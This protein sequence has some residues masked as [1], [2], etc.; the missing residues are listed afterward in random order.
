MAF[1]V[2]P[3]SFFHAQNQLKLFA[4]GTPL[5]YSWRA[6]RSPSR[7]G[8][9]KPRP[10][11]HPLRG[12]WR[13]DSGAFGARRRWTP[14][15]LISQINLWLL[16]CDRPCLSQDTRVGWRWSV[17]WA[18]SC[19]KIPVQS[20]TNLLR[21]LLYFLAWWQW[22]S[23]SKLINKYYFFSFSLCAWCQCACFTSLEMVS[24][25]VFLAMHFEKSM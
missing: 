6:S 19:W 25:V 23:I 3:A 9:G 16:N 24:K 1:G 4:A 14:K 17:S 15:L 5:E 2:P 12:L 22:C 7:L 21:L 13:L 18:K 8:G 20:F 11:P 10:R